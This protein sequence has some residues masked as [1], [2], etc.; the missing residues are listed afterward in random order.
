MKRFVLEGFYRPGVESWGA[1]EVG[2]KGDVREELYYILH[3]DAGIIK[4]VLLHLRASGG[5]NQFR[6]VV[7]AARFSPSWYASYGLKA[8]EDTSEE[9]EQDLARLS[10]LAQSRIVKMRQ[11]WSQ[12]SANQ[13]DLRSLARELA[14]IS[15]PHVRNLLPNQKDL[16]T[17]LVKSL[18]RLEVPLHDAY[19]YIEQINAESRR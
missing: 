12:L 18:E 6:V 16:A 19:S 10:E 5:R 17:G 2:G 3:H 15:T 11:L 7:E 4:E 1:R 13:R 9:W 14:D 8:T